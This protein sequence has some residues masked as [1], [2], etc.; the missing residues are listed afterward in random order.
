[1]EPN[2]IFWLEFRQAKR[3]GLFLALLLLSILG[4]LGKFFA[5]CL[6]LLYFGGK[7]ASQRLNADM[8]LNTPLSPYQILNGKIL[9]GLLCGVLVYTPAFIWALFFAPTGDARWLFRVIN[10]FLAL[11]GTR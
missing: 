4:I 7:I 5:Y 10:G 9:F 3:N 1:M 8:V 2:A 6:L 11:E